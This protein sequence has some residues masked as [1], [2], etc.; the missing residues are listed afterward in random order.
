MRRECGLGGA[1]SARVISQLFEASPLKEERERLRHE[2]MDGQKAKVVALRSAMGTLKNLVPRAKQ[3]TLGQRKG[4]SCF[5]R[6][7]VDWGEI[8]E[9]KKEL[10]ALGNGVDAVFSLRLATGHL[11]VCFACGEEDNAK[12]CDD[13][14]KDFRAAE[15]DLS[16]AMSHIKEDCWRDID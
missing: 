14:E 3:L 12:G 2:C 7:Q 4:A 10:D 16:V 15:K 11:R 1:C 6:Q 9:T 5:A 8:A 13:A